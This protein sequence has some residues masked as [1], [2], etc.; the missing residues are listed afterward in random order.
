MGFII[1]I[2]TAIVSVVT[3]VVAIIAPIL[4]YLAIAAAAYVYV[5]QPFLGSLTGNFG[6]DAGGGG[7]V[8]SIPEAQRQQGVLVTKTGSDSDIPV[9]YGHRKVGTSINFAETGST[10]NQ[11]LYVAYILGEGPIEGLHEGFI[12]DYQLP[13]GIIQSLNNGQTVDVSEGKYAG[14][15]QLQF[16]HGKYFNNPNDSKVGTWSILKDAPSW[17]TSMKYNG[18]AVLFAR[19]YWKK[20]ETQEDAD[21][22][23]FG[24]NIPEV[25]AS[26]L[27]RKVASISNATNNDYSARTERYSTNPVEHLIDYLSNPRYGKGLLL[28]DFDWTSVEKAANKCNQKVEYV[29]GVYGPI[30]TNNMVVNT[31]NSIFNNTKSLL[32]GFRGYMPYVQGKYKLKIEDAGNEDD[33]LS[34]VA[35]IVNTFDEDN[36][37]G[38][39][40]YSGI[41]RGSKYNSVKVG[42]VDPDNKWSNA[43][44]IYPETVSARQTYIDQDGGRINQAD[45]FMAGVTNYA[46]AKD[47]ARLIFNKSRF[48]ESLSFTVSSEGLELEPGDNVYVETKMMSFPDIPWRV[49]SLSINNDMTV[50]LALVRNKD[51]I[52]PH[53]RVGEE[54]IVLPVYVPRG[55]T[56]YYPAVQNTIP[57]GLVPPTN[58]EV[59]RVYTPPTIT[60]VTPN[61]FATPG[62]NTVTVFGSNFKSGVTAKWIGND[63]TEYPAV[64]VVRSG[65][66]RIDVDT[67]NSMVAANQPYSLKV[68]NSSAYGN[69]S[70]TANSILN[71]DGTNPPSVDDPVNNPVTVDPPVVVDP[72][73]PDV[74][75]P[76]STPP[77]TGES[78]TNPPPDGPVNAPLTDTMEITNITFQ[79]EDNYVTAVLTGKIPQNAMYLHTV[80]YYRREGTQE[81]FYQQYNATKNIP[82]SAVQ[83]TIE[84]LIP[85][86]TYEV[87]SRVAY[88]SGESSANTNKIVFDAVF[89]GQIDPVD[90]VQ[91][92]SKAWPTAPRNPNQDR[93]NPITIVS[94]T[95]NLS[96]GE[97][98]TPGR[99]L[100]VVIKQDILAAEPN[101]EIEGYVLYA[102]PSNRSYWTRAKRDEFVGP[103]DPL[104][105]SYVPGQNITVTIG[106]NDADQSLGVRS[107]P[108]LP[109]DADQN[110]D[111]LFRWQY[112]MTGYGPSQTRIVNVPVEY[113]DS[114]YSFDP[115]AGAEVINESSL[116]FNLVVGPPP[117]PGA[118]LES[119]IRIN[120]IGLTQERG[121]LETAVYILPPYASGVPSTAITQVWRGVDF[122]VRT[123]DGY[124]EVPFEKISD[125]N[126]TLADGNRYK[127]FIPLPINKNFELVVVPKFLDN[128]V[129]TQGWYAQYGYGKILSDRNSPQYPTEGLMDG[130][131]GYRAFDDQFNF[132][133]SQTKDA[134]L[135][136]KT[137]EVDA[138]TDINAQSSILKFK[139]ETA[140]QS[141]RDLDYYFLQWTGNSLP[142]FDG[143]NI[144]RRNVN[145]NPVAVDYARNRHGL[146]RWERI[147]ASGDG[148]VFLRAGETY[149]RFNKNYNIGASGF[150][151]VVNSK[152]NQVA[153]GGYDDF[154]VVSVINGVESSVGWLMPRLNSNL[155]YSGNSVDLLKGQRPVLVS[156][157]DYNTEAVELGKNLNQWRA[158]PD[159]DQ[160][161]SYLGI[162]YTSDR[163]T[164][165]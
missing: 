62:T 30:L 46:I 51:D 105:N 31:G 120:G 99:S 55:A 72:S 83:I 164:F 142:G 3:A 67:V 79:R 57:I 108:T 66:G 88:S 80:F 123:I 42:Y 128:G 121:N 112:R 75:P 119:I 77:D 159:S 49:I 17:K 127:Y 91:E 151:M 70:A 74:T 106:A 2:I 25:Q 146:G 9:V 81:P 15:V 48:Q 103:Y 150:N 160:C 56:I 60:S 141:F 163:N 153:Q 84:R 161:T 98:T 68:I 11:Y 116:D 38:T 133:R 139:F 12:D 113:K 140:G 110:Y 134:L 109:T 111:F 100:T 87:I 1:P 129:V 7:G 29:N 131:G 90:Y 21:D 27:G 24:G 148:Y 47:F 138:P 95:T 59:P 132:I 85:N 135:S 19:Y 118:A 104:P 69:L 156:L 20:I 125:S 92:S 64:T 154:I 44:V 102:K 4:P 157:S 32:T 53:T 114:S 144:Y 94:S 45:V 101:Y 126:K 61:S 82:G 41:Q 145:P 52:Y 107:Y 73:D 89:T 76:P 58:A 36:I 5:A 14:R 22:N 6:G 65:D 137:P 43:E 23:P 78:V 149:E 54:D 13:S 63:T 97:P 50:D 136:A 18:L 35:T 96:G 115:F 158:A 124:Q 34:G 37:V 155:T 117:A 10:D 16:S 28:K 39:V 143:V 130:G 165:K 122:Y 26:I 147:T 33:I 40:T 8:G 71:V 86:E 162:P 93:N 152:N